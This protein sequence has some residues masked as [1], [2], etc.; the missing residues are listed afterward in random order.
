MNIFW[1]HFSESMFAFHLALLSLNLL[2]DAESGCS[3]VVLDWTVA[4]AHNKTASSITNA[5]RPTISHSA[6]LL[7]SF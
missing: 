7:Q 4:M 3:Q 1:L 5:T 6:Y 2:T